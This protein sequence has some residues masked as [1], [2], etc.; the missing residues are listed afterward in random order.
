MFGRSSRLAQTGLLVLLAAVT[1]CGAGAGKKKDKG[2]ATTA[3]VSSAAPNQGFLPPG[4]QGGSAQTTGQVDTDNDGLTD[5]QEL[6]FGT[7]PRNPD[8]D[9]DGIIDGRDLAPLY[10]AGA[11]GPFETQ[12]PRGAVATSQEY[13][14]CGMYG[15]SKVEKW[16][17]GWNTTYTGTKAT[18]SSDIQKAQVL[19]DM[20]DKTA[21]SDYVVVGADEKGPLST[22]DTHEYKKTVV[23]SRYTIDYDF[24]SQ[25]YDV[26]FRNRIATSLRDGKQAT[27]ATR[28][29]PVHVE[30][31]HDS[32]V[33]V[34]F[35]IDKGAD[36]YSETPTAY[37][38]P[39]VTYQVFA[40]T[41]LMGSA[42]VLDDVATAATLNPDA[43]EVRLPLPALKGTG[44]ADWTV[45]LTPVWVSKSGQ[46]A[47]SVEA[48]DAGNLRIGA[49]AHDMGLVKAADSMQR[50]TAV[51]QDLRS[52]ATDLRKAAA[53][54][55]FA[56]ATTQ[57]KTVIQKAK[58]QT[59]LEFTLSLVRS[60][61][62]LAKTG[63]GLLIQTGE[64]TT[65]SKSGDLLSLLTPDEARRY[66]AFVDTLLK[67]ENASMAVVHGYQAVVAIQQGDTIRAVLY[68]ARSATEAFL[69]IGDSEIVRAGAAAAAFA[70]DAY[71]ALQ[72]FRGG[73]NL[74]GGLYVLRASASLISAFDSKLG[75]AASAILSA[76]TNG[77][78]A[79]NA[80]KQGDTVLGLVNVAHGTGAL[81]RYFFAN[82][83]I[84]GL[85]VGSV[86]TAAL[87]VVDVGYNVYLATQTHD[88]ILRQRYVE[89]AVAAALDTA[90]ML[91]PTVGPVIEAVWQIGYTALTMIFPDLAKYRMFR[92]PGAFLTFVGQVFF[93]NEIPS[94]YAEDAFNEA[95]DALAKKVD[96]L[97]QNGE[98]AWVVWPTTT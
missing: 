39:A 81:A 57:T 27:F 7:D 36:R 90:I 24:K 95:A 85:P 97:Q 71:D 82:D 8:T 88:P 43:Y 51:F 13:R 47:A 21:Q 12:Y 79:Y 94:A 61:A 89:D 6:F 59:G 28:N 58:T 33:I 52:T 18:R 20:A 5:D 44:G 64:H 75:G 56:Q 87:G 41:D 69:L 68:G 16:A 78:A 91:I 22:F 38:I 25:Q 84:A 66:Q 32:T 48:I 15:R 74:R 42:L 9:G 34:Q 14:V 62:A 98:F 19:K 63:V 55:S 31:G 2:Q 83:S 86:I 54:A 10:G 11:Y 70:S 50:V 72:A 53:A 67:V 23:Y 1:G 73:D 45:V 40:G 60:T 30:A 49:V 65:F 3:G 4:F 17:F 80:F 92:S 76:G 46:A 96:A 35:S 77:I 29:F 26:A 37:T 93:T